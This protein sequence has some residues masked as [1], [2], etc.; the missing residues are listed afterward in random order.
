MTTRS[1]TPPL[2]EG[3]DDTE[4]LDAEAANDTRPPPLTPEQRRLFNLGMPMVMQCAGEIG[5]R[6][7]YPREDLLGAGT[8]ALE[9]SARC[10]ERSEHPNFP[11]YARHHIRGRMIDALRDDR[12]SRKERIE[13]VMERAFEVVSSHHV[14]RASLFED[15]DEQI[16]AGAR[17]GATE[18]AAAAYLAGLIDKQ[19][20]DSEEGVIERLWLRDGVARLPPHEQAV[21]RLVY[22][23]SLT[24]DQAAAELGISPNTAQRRHAAAL[25]KLHQLLAGQRS[26]KD[27]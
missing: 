18:V 24:L 25:R 10:Y 22:W 9:E 20:E 23:K 2:P 27:P 11:V 12:C 14:V 4:A 16:L 26:K 5:A 21:M 6:H 17:E 7:R 3:G 15:S 13:R 19:K 8:V 1:K